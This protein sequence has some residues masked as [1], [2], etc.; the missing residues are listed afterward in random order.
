MLAYAIAD[1]ATSRLTAL[2]VSP[3]RMPGPTEVKVRMTASSINPID[4]LLVT[5]HGS[6]LLNPRGDFPRVLGRDGVGLIVAIGSAVRHLR[7]GQRVVLAVS[8]RRNGTYAEQVTLPAVCACA[9]DD[10]LIDDVAAVIGYAGSTAVQALRTADVDPDKA[11]GRRVLI[12]GASGGLGTIA[13]QMAVQWGAQVTAV[14]ASRNHAWLKELGASRTMDYEEAG[15]LRTLPADTVIDFATP[16]SEGSGDRGHDPLLAALQRSDG[17]RAYATVITPTLGLVTRYGV[18]PGLLRAGADLARRK[19]GALMHGV[20]YRQVL[21]RED[22][23]ALA[24]V[25]DF[26]SQPLAR[27]VVRRALAA[28]ALPVEFSG[29]TELRV[30]G[31]TLV[32]FLSRGPV[33]AQE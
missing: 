28:E 2:D 10:T 9:V 32:H 21:F 30:P 24:T 11:R 16:S 15:S 14:C 20:R 23:K 3:A 7:V 22:A 13:A 33:I 6:A 29:G 25:A 1:R 31:K 12:Y 5:G 4:R 18:V 19:A 26:F 17:R 27:S 8:P